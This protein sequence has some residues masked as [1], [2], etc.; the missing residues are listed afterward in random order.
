MI[1]MCQHLLQ[2]C[3]LTVATELLSST[4]TKVN[5]QCPVKSYKVKEIMQSIKHRF[6]IAFGICVI[7]VSQL[8]GCATQ[9]MPNR[10]PM[11]TQ[12]LNHFRI[13][14]SRRQEQI[15]F[16]QNMRVTRDEQFASRMRVMLKPYEIITDPGA[17]YS[18]HDIAYRN[19]NKYINFLL[20]ELSTC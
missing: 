12:D 19:T 16:L 18:N 9:P 3:Q 5:W 6:A 4:G 11:A 14:C 13:D 20:K 17:Y 1:G 2:S 15:A 7:C 8:S 10:I